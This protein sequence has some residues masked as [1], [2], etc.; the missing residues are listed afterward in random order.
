M[1]GSVGQALRD[2]RLEK[3]LTI[4]EAA[5]ATRIR[6]SRIADLEDDDYTHF[7]NIAY[8]RSFLVLYAKFLDVDISKYPTVEVGNTAG[9]GDYQYLR[10][11]ESPAP[12]YRA[13]PELTG[14]PQKPRWLIVFFVLLV[15]LAIGAL[16]GWTIM[17]IRRLGP[18]SPEN[19]AKKDAE[20]LSTPTP[21]PSPTPSPT[22]APPAAG[23]TPEEK[24]L[25]AVPAA[26]PEPEIRRAEPIAAETAAPGATPEAATE[27]VMAAKPVSSP[28]ATPAGT[29]VS[30]ETGNI[31]PEG[32][33][34]EIGIRSTKKIK[35]RVEK[36]GEKTSSLY[37]GSIN[38]L[39]KPLLF[40]GKT[41]LIKTAEPEAL[42]VTVNGQPITGPESGVEIQGT[43]L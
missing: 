41:F 20:A 1:Q 40:R 4:D 6:A 19:M 37:F 21:T 22:P 9:L 29:V 14:P 35:I 16:A 10:G 27:P 23:A 11:E 18:M 32:T 12:T 15:A 2:A 43:G 42:K 26:S 25:P 3:K 5:H 39:M 8:A 38:P 36:D 7:P 28:A 33:E 34:R 30:A 31:P 24:I 13:R 17:T